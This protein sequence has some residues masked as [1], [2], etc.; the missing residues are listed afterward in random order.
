MIGFDNAARPSG[1]LVYTS[2]DGQLTPEQFSR[3]KGVLEAGFQGAR[4]AGR[5]MLVLPEASS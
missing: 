1:A 4:N 5:P 2:R 3:L